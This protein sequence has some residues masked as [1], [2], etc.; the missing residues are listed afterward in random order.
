MSRFD[1]SPQAER[2]VDVNPCTSARGSRTDFPDGIARSGVHISSLRANDGA[3]V[4]ARQFI[5]PHPS[6][7]VGTYYRN[8]RFP[9]TEQR[10]CLAYRNMRFL[11]HHYRQLR[12]TEQSV[13]LNVPT[14]ARKQRVTRG[15]QSGQIRTHCS[16]N[17]RG[18]TIRRQAEKLQEPRERD[19][20]K[21]GRGRRHDPQ[22]TVLVPRRGERLRCDTH[23]I[24]R[25]IH[26]TEVA[27]SIRRD[28]GGRT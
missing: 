24:S 1:A 19:I 22:R 14:C 5:C 12:R 18:G 28:C 9:Q 11:T 4:Q 3:F 2:A 23:R 27:W 6:L 26:E 17:Q 15:G 8:A 7:S 16:G 21:R 10:Q 20:L 13:I 25:A